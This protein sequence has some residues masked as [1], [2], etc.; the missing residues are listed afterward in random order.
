MKFVNRLKNFF[1]KPKENRAMR[2]FEEYRLKDGKKQMQF[3]KDFIQYAR[4]HR[5]RPK[6]GR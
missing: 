5:C 3:R 6:K 2:R 1:R 4:F